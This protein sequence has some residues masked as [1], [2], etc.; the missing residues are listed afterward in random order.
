VELSRKLEEFSQAI[1][2]LPQY[3][4]K[5][6]AEAFLVIPRTLA[7]NAGMDS[8]QVIS[9]LLA[10]HAAG[11]VHHGVDIEGSEKQIEDAFCRDIYELVNVKQSAIDLAANAALTIL[12]ID[13]V[14]VII[15]CR[16]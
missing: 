9:K 3:S 14:E 13:Q 5:K 15:D 12:R 1:T 2:G 10:A 11:N 8:F 6:F 4:I 16:L 7:E